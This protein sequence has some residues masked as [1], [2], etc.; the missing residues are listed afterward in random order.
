M[1][2]EK[3]SCGVCLPGCFST[4]K[5]LFK[6]FTIS[7]NLQK[8]FVKSVARR[9]TF[10]YPRD[11]GA[12]EERIGSRRNWT[13][14]SGGRASWRPAR[15]RSFFGEK[16]T[17]SKAQEIVL[18]TSCVS[19]SRCRHQ[20]DEPTPADVSKFPLS[21]RLAFV[22]IHLRSSSW[23]TSHWRWINRRQEL[24]CKQPLSTASSPGT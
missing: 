21:R 22:T 13:R 18:P 19:C 17:A 11:R 8:D 20:P 5:N 14:P 4:S 16:G 23:S 7:A 10:A 15:R 1:F 24:R 3:I 9:W 2:T 6:N 12:F